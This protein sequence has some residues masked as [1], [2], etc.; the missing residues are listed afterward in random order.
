MKK[1]LT[2]CMICND[3]MVL[4]GMK[5]RG[6]GTGRWNG[7]G[8]KVESGESVEAAAIREVEE[9]V[10]VTPTSMKQVGV[11]EFAF[12]SEENVLEVHVFK[13]TVY[14][15]EPVESEEMRP[16]WFHYSEVPFA[17]MWADDRYWFPYLQSDMLF[18]GRFL[19]DRPATL[20]HPGTI[21]EHELFEVE[22]I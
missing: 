21:V 15:G 9:E 3:E 2:L 19:F 13:V 18:K 11:L 20:E 16:Q 4:L 22:S 10:G 14:T 7:F 8:G 17:Q 5:K 12:Q 1:I 6:F